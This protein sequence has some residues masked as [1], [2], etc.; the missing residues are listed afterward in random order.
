[1]SNET[2]QYLQSKILQGYNEMREMNLEIQVLRQQ[3]LAKSNWIVDNVFDAPDSS[4]IKNDLTITP[5]TPSG[6]IS[7]MVSNLDTI[8]IPLEVEG[9]EFPVNWNVRVVLFYR[10]VFGVSGAA[11]VTLTPFDPTA[12]TG[13]FGVFRLTRTAFNEWVIEAL[14]DNTVLLG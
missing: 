6:Q 8:E 12:V 4:I 7:V 2:I 1:M 3:I 5:A 13:M 10:S 11:G 14:T 9:D